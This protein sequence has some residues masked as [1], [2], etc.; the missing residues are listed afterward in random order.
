MELPSGTYKLTASILSPEG[1]EYG[2]TTVTVTDHDVAG[3]VFH[4]APVPALPVELLAEPQATPDDPQPSIQQLGLTLENVASDSD[5]FNSTIHPVTGRDRS[6]SF[7]VPPGSYRLRAQSHSSWYIRSA[8]YGGSDL[9]QQA[10]TIGPGAGGTP[11]IIAA[12]DQTAN[13]QGTCRLGGLPANCWIYLTPSTPSAES[14]FVEQSGADGAYN[15]AHLP[16]GTYQAIAFEQRHSADYR[17][18]ATLTPF[19]THIRTLTINTGEK[20]VLDLDAVSAAEIVP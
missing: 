14:V 19:A 8:T 3:V 17:D 18:P 11:I 12:S 13:L 7:T 1:T 20:S 9:L 15:Y 16:P 10:L 5:I 6:V 2:E 4:L